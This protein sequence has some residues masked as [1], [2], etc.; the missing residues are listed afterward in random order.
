MSKKKF[1]NNLK[2]PKNQK[3]KR[4]KSWERGTT[5][6]SK[7]SKNSDKSKND[8]SEIEKTVKRKPKFMEEIELFKKDKIS[9]KP[10]QSE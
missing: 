2:T 4:K 9:E 3:R 6:K 8:S 5:R 1:G 10:S 7:V